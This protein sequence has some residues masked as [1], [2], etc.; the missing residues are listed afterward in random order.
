[1]LHKGSEVSVYIYRKVA[2]LD[3][4]HDPTY[5]LLAMPLH[6][7][8]QPFS[9]NEAA[10]SDQLFANVIG[11]FTCKLS[12]DLRDDDLVKINDEIFTVTTREPY[13]NLF[14]HYEVY[15]SHSQWT[16]RPTH[17]ITYNSNG[18]DSGIVPV[19]SALYETNG[20]ITVSDNSGVLIKAGKTFSGWNTV[21]DGSG[22]SYLP[23]S[24]YT[25]GRADVTFYAQWV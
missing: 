16:P 2:P 23:N 19:D 24:S 15:V 22:D 6:V 20:V 18:A 17:S 11:Y 14:P 9:S 10:R 4:T 5:K 12:V 21:A 7:E 13:R 1:M 3:E 25:F 8:W